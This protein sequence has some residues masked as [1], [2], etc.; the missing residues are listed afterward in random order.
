MKTGEEKIRILIYE[1]SKENWRNAGILGE[2]MK[3]EWRK[4]MK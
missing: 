4:E 2:D 3:H 1:V